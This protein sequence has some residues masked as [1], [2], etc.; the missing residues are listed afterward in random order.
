[1]LLL[2]TSPGTRHSCRPVQAD[3]P[4]PRDAML[5][6]EKALAEGALA[7]IQVVLGW[8]I[9]THW[10]LIS[11]SPEK[12]N[13]W[14]A[15]LNAALDTAQSNGRLRH[16]DLEPLLQDRMASPHLSITYGTC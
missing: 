8:L 9:D 16:H 1:M 5:A 4:L 11:L 14:I 2:G 10:L 12:F 3:E 7:E 6:I 13:W 15:E